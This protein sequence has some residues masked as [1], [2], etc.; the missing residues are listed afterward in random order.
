VKLELQ[1]KQWEFESDCSIVWL[2]MMNFGRTIGQLNFV[3]DEYFIGLNALLTDNRTLTER[4][5]VNRLLKINHVYTN[6]KIKKKKINK[7]L[8]RKKSEIG[9]FR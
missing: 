8:K 6:Q 9:Y 4:R 7:Q 1:D 3:R 2:F 5:F